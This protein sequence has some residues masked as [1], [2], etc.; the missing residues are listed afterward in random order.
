[1][2]SLSSISPYLFC[3]DDLSIVKNGVLKS[4]IIVTL[5]CI[6]P[7]RSVNI[8]FMYLSVPMLGNIYLQLLYSLDELTSLSLYNDLLCS[9]YS[10]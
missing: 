4:P 6:S 5:L 3:L 10:F 1:M 9:C 7:Y 8:C 2:C